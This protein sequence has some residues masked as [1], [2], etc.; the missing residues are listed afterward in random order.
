MKAKKTKKLRETAPDRIYLVIGDDTPDD[1]DFNECSE[2]S[3]ATEKLTKKSIEYVKVLKDRDNEEVTCDGCINDKGCIACVDH[4]LKQTDG[5][6][7]N[8]FSQGFDR[9]DEYYDVFA[10][11]ELNEKSSI[12]EK[13]RLNRILSKDFNSMTRNERMSDSDWLSLRPIDRLAAI[14]MLRDID[15]KRVIT[16]EEMMKE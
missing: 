11:V 10:K 8:G 5:G 4:N 3:W 7:W 16:L 15:G 1:V 14:G 2:I 12:M 13:E 9:V 6:E